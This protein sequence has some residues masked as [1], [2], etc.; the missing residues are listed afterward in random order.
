MFN[1]VLG[2]YRT[3]WATFQYLDV[4]GYYWSSTENDPNSAYILYF[5]GGAER[6]ESGYAFKIAGHSVR[7]IKL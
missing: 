6:V 7:C 1:F 5:L 3:Y 4:D 2:G